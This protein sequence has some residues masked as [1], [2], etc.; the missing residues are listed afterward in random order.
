VAG[1]RV[2]V[3]R[4]LDEQGRIVAVYVSARRAAE[5]AATFFRRALAATGVAPTAVT[6]DG[7]AAS[8]PTRAAVLLA[9]PHETG[10]APRRRIEREHRYRKGRVRGMRGRKTLAGA[11]VS[12]RAR[13]SL[14][15]LRGGF[16][17]LGRLL[18]ASPRPTVPATVSGREAPTAEL[19][20][21]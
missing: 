7:A 11:K 4:A 16:Y 5:D 3:Y 10:K 21:W 20:T 15:T 14:R 19:L 1:D 2:S 12:C 18:G 6:T 9:A 13:A 8:P 17:D